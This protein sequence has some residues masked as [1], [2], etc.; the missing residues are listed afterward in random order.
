MT[1][2]T[3]PQLLNF[4]EFLVW[5]PDGRRFELIDGVAIEMQPTGS[6]ENITE[7]LS[8]QL[9]LATAQA[10]LPYRFPRQA[11]LKADGWN[12]GFLPDVLVV[13]AQALK[14]EERWAKEAT[15][16]SGKTIKL[17]V[18]VVSTNWENDYARKTEDYAEMG[19][20]EYWIVDY[21]GL[22]GKSYIGIPKQPT[23]SIYILDVPSQRYLQP[24]LFRSGDIIRSTTF[25][26]WAI[27]V[28]QIFDAAEP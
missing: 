26:R 4:E 8:T 25:P 9:T 15:I 16:C 1:L 3:Q 6:H 24:Q 12:T 11:L 28:D 13:D 7:F 22:G 19:I 14:Q 18:E 10:N 20:P 21:L 17:A 23:I 5:K 27:T 2:A